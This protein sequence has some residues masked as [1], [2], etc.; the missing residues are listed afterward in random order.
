MG[1]PKRPVCSSSLHRGRRKF[2]SRP[3]GAL[4]PPQP[5]LASPTTRRMP[6]ENPS[7]LHQATTSPTP[8]T[9]LPPTE[10]PGG[11]RMEE[12][13]IKTIYYYLLPSCSIQ[14][15]VNE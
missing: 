9:S 7:E 13:K 8:S 12:I 6:S 14:I 10:L 15:S 1:F 5:P 2:P 3:G 4:I 11:S